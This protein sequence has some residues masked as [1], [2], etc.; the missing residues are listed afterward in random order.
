[1]SDKD[2]VIEAVGL[3]KSFKD[4]WGRPKAKAVND[5]SFEVKK[6]E[7]FG[8]LGPNGSG[9]STT[10]K[11]LLGLLYPSR[12]ALQVFGKSPRDVKVKQRIGYLPEETYLY[13]YLSAHETVDFFGALFQLSREDRKK[14]TQQLIEMVGLKNAGKRAVG[15]YSKGMARRVGLAQALINDPDLIILDEPTSGL[16]PIGCREVK[17]LIK[18]LAQRGKTVILSSHLLADVQDVVDRVVVLYGGQIRAQ[19]TIDELLLVENKTKIVT[20]RMSKETLDR[21]LK[22]LHEEYSPEQLELS[23]PK[24]DLETFFLDVVNR[25]RKEDVHT[26]GAQA[27]DFADYLK[28]AVVEKAQAADEE[29][30]EFS[31][32]KAEKEVSAKL[33]EIVAK[34]D[35]PPQVEHT[36]DPKENN[37]KV[38]EKLSGLM[39]NPPV[40]EPSSLEKEKEIIKTQEEDLSKV[41]DKLKNLLGK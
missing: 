1:M 11:M 24:L 19:G 32:L 21:V 37:F 8:L 6:G 40:A 28:G 39:E 27:G 35:Q 30:G 33:A 41:N 17:N 36:V 31:A 15:E 26:A 3:T 25:A 23:H 13:K 5:I 38:E 18:T 9:K 4:F 12:G 20:P 29:N 10:I 2:V 7:V 22:I 14:R 16:D 34:D